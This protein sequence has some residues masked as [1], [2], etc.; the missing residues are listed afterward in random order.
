M[1]FF[2]GFLTSSYSISLYFIEI[3]RKAFGEIS[4]LSQNWFVI[5]LS[6]TVFTFIL[7][8]FFRFYQHCLMHKIPLLW[9][10]H[11][12]HHSAEV[13]TPLTLNRMH[14]VEMF[15]SMART[16]LVNAISSALYVYLFQV[17]LYGFDILG[18]NM[19]GFLFNAIGA[20]LR[21][22]AVWISYGPLEYL[23]IS[24]AQHQVHHSKDP[25]HF[26]K[27]FGICFSAWDLLFRSFYRANKKMS[28]QFGLK[29]KAPRS[30]KDAYFRL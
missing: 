6:Y 5:R 23:F 18:V 19:F 24:P 2:A 7:L 12:V 9:K 3:F 22:S 21:H 26:N 8:D 20:N 17:P 27:N 4:P 13:L 29:D 1:I 14:P 30:V 16:V 15:I 10:F 25:L 11:Q 28:L